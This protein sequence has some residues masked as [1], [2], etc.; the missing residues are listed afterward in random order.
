VN[1][2]E[3]LFEAAV[4]EKM[5]SL[6]N[7]ACFAVA[8]QRL[9]RSVSLGLRSFPTSKKLIQATDLFDRM[10]SDLANQRERRA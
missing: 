7:A 2:D 1:P 8:L 5:L 4:L 9:R 10:L 6:Y 3:G